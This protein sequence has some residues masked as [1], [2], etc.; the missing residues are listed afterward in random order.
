ME[1]SAPGIRTIVIDPGHGG[2]DA[3]VKGPG[4]TEEKAYVLAFARRLKATIESRIGLRVLLTRERDE[5]MPIDRRAALANNNK[6]DLFISLHANASARPAVR[7][8]QVLSLRLDDY[9]SRAPDTGGPDIPVA[10]L[11]GGTRE[12][13]VLPWDMAQIGF[14]A[15]SRVVADTLRRH[16][17]AAGVP[18]L[19]M[20]ATELAL[21]PLVGVN[22]PAVLVELGML[23]NADDERALNGGDLPVKLIDSILNTIAEI[24]QGIRTP[25]ETSATAPARPQ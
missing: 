25:P 3:G 22:M 11:G 17:T 6:A 1:M 8:A 21:R 5:D 9:S 12:V 24:R 13:S 2:D 15:E 4:G 7:G 20:P 10:V 18:L 19:N 14:T 16:L 23:S